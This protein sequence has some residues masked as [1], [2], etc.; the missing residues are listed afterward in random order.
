MKHSRRRV[1][2]RGFEAW[3]F[4]NLIGALFKCFVFS[5]FRL[6]RYNLVPDFEKYS[7]IKMIIDYLVVGFICGLLGVLGQFTAI[8]ILL[9]FVFVPLFLGITVRTIQKYY[10]KKDAIKQQIVEQEERNG[11]LASG[12]FYDELL[13][14][15]INGYK[16][17]DIIEFVEKMKDGE[18]LA[19]TDSEYMHCAKRGKPCEW[20]IV[21]VLEVSK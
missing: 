3:G 21:K 16:L 9:S 17:L 7:A 18:K 10:A 8:I 15:T 5:P 14:H 12:G 11:C 13:S 19:I 6:A 20:C 2:D 1:S 4:E